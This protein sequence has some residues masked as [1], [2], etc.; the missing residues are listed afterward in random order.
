MVTFLSYPIFQEVILPFL[1]VFTL[2]FA[3]LEKANLLGKDKHQINAITGFVIA[4]I[5]I[6]FTQY[7]GWIQNFSI[8]L[9]IGLFII[10]VFLLLY[11]F[12]WGETSGDILKNAVGLKWALGIIALVAVIWATLYI[13]GGI[14]Y[15]QANPSI[16]TNVIFIV[17]IIAAIVVVMGV[18]NKKE[19]KD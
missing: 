1:L 7:V 15:V 5:V 10:F 9:V 14:A 12:I 11:G 18:G 13:T 17:L 4:A 16:L 8:F 3:I 19:K 6:S 2:L